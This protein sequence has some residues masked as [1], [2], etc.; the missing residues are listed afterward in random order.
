MNIQA[1]R[2]VYQ[3]GRRIKKWIERGVQIGFSV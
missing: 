2:I 1:A 3:D